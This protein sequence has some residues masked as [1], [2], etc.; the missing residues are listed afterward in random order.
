MAFASAIL[1]YFAI[2][3]LAVAMVFII[4][5][6][7]NELLDMGTGFAL[8]VLIIVGLIPHGEQPRT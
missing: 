3:G 6:P 8:G 7:W 4:V 2:V 5:K 1:R